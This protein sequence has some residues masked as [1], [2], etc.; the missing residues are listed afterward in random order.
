MGLGTR[1]GPSWKP[2]P[3]LFTTPFALDRRPVGARAVARHRPGGR[4]LA[5]AFTYR[6]ARAAGGLAAG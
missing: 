5:F 2:L 3:V 6:L 1:T 4:L